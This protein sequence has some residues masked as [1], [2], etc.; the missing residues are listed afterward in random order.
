MN[1][2]RLIVAGAGHLGRYHAQKAMA[3]DC[4][5]LVGIMDID[6]DK[7]SALAHEIGVP[8]IDSYSADTADAMVVA[9]TT[10]AHHDVACEALQAGLHALVEKPIASTV[11]Q[12]NQM[13]ETALRHNRVLAV[14][15]SERYNPA[16]SAALN[17]ANRPRYITAERLSPFS[18]RSLDVDVILDLMIHDLDILSFLV[19]SPLKEARA[20]GVP[21]L[22]NSVDMASA[23][24]EFEDGTVAEL[25]A[26]RVS[27]EPCRKIRIFTEERYISIDCSAREVKAVK[28]NAP[29]EGQTMGTITG[30]PVAV[31]E[32]DPLEEQMK[33]FAHSI[34]NQT[35]PKVTGAAGTRA[36]ELACA[37]RQCMTNP[38]TT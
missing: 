10:S 16:V 36:L 38:A 33:N 11:H 3:L 5:N 31:P 37:V 30:D 27:M 26:G 4:I 29:T 1:P 34:A 21:V 28:I 17:L 2:I 18:G 7:A 13:V 24:L 8:V 6:P 32:W 14:G 12:A 23:R 19:A 20:I 35:E 15:H 25:Q 9:T 22:T